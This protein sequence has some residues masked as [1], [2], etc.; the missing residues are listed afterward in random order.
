MTIIDKKGYY[1][2]T[3]GDLFNASKGY[4][5]VQCIAR[6]CNYAHGIAATFAERFPAMRD[7]LREQV[8]NGIFDKKME[9]NYNWTTDYKPMILNYMSP[10]DT[11]VI[12][13]MDK[14][15]STDKPKSKDLYRTLE[16]LYL[17]YREEGYSL[18]MPKI[19]SGIDEI[20]W[21]ETKAKLIE[22]SN[23]Y[24]VSTVVFTG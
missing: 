18:A 12:N 2:E 23:E 5:L 1:I 10:E 16:N 9:I 3:T 24:E 22:F 6:D 14:D 13:I 21:E 17:I 8:V 7:N 15:E 11:L 19:G 4:A 20:N